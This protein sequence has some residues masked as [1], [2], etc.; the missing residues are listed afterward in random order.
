MFVIDPLES[1]LTR[2]IKPFADIEEGAEYLTWKR[3]R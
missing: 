2:R 3:N 1:A